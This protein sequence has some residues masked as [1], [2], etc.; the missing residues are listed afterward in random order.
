[1]QYAKPVMRMQELVN[2]GFPETF[3]LAA[4]RSRGQTFAQKKD[5]AKS[6]SPILFDTEE[7]EKWRMRRL[8]SENKALPRK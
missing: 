1:M 7:F 3:L 6:N 8:K 4:Y 2:M 5:P